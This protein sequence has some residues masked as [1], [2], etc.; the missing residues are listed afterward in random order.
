MKHQIILILVLGIFLNAG[1]QQ[2][3]LFS[4]YTENPYLINPG[5]AGSQEYSPIRLL[6]R[7]QWSGLKNA[8]S[9]KLL[10]GHMRSNE[11]GIGG[12]VFNDSYGNT[13][14]TGIQLSYAYHLKI[15]D[16]TG[17]GIGLSGEAFQFSMDQSNYNYHDNNDQVLTNEKVAV[18]IPNA[19]AGIFIYNPDFYAGLSVAQ[20]FG[21]NAKVALNES[22]LNR[23]KQHILITGA[24]NI[25]LNNELTLTP[26]LL[27]RYTTT[28]PFEL[29]GNLIVKYKKLF[30]IGIGYR[31][32]SALSI[33]ASAGYKN[34]IFSYSFDY[35]TKT[36]MPNKTSHE[37]LLGINLNAK[38]SGNSL[39][40]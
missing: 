28:A 31:S 21:V 8:P 34:F 2:L 9:T 40:K 10:Y 5:A 27:S 35:N 24:Y 14:R 13:S 33:L 6:A 39:I 36:F 11:M 17:L 32:T 19:D 20:L 37:I 25:S 12:I 23:M 18:F 15:N 3:P 22:D 16:E 30:G 26:S 4:Q 7:N 29:E 38:K 1:A